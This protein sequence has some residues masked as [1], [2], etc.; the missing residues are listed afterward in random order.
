MFLEYRPYNVQIINITYLVNH[1][2]GLVRKY[3]H[4]TYLQ[5]GV[6]QMRSVVGYP[7]NGPFLKF[8]VFIYILVSSDSRFDTLS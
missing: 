2:I 1:N 5:R 4:T 3:V 8:S 6:S 7:Y